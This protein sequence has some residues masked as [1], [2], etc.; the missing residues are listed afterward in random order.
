MLTQ[1]ETNLLNDLKKDEQICIEKYNKY[2]S[3][4]SSP[5]L[6]SLF[7]QLGQQEQQHLNSI[8]Q[9][10]NGTVPNV[11][12]N[13]SGAATSNAQ[14][15]NSAQPS[16]YTDTA[17]KQNDSYLCT[18]TLSTEKYVSSG[19]NTSIFE[20]Q[21]SNVRNVLNHIQKEEQEH[22]KAIYD[23]MAQNGMYN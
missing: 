4:A 22:G 16:N 6:K 23:Y 7:Q 15:Q 19:Y 5:Q 8:N 20:F 11:N 1:K 17:N 12:M 18:D 14:A 13:N 9:I 2:S 21:D 3:S 10:L